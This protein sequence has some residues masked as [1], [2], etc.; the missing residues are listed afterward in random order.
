MRGL[1]RGRQADKVQG[2]QGAKQ[3]Q[4]RPGGRASKAGDLVPWS[5]LLSGSLP[6]AGSPAVFRP[7]DDWDSICWSLRNLLI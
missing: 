3:L 5:H 1:I 4:S 6:A 7:G 2:A